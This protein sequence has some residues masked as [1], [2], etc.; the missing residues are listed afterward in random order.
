M[1]RRLT[2]FYVSLCVLLFL[3]NMLLAGDIRFL[4]LNVNDGLSQGSVF[5]IMQDYQ[6]FM[7]IGTR[8]GLNKYDSRKFTTYRNNPRDSTSI[9][10][11]F[12][13]SIMEDSR[14]RLWVATVDGL[15]LYNRAHDNF[16]RIRLS[17]LQ[18]SSTKSE[19]L[20]YH[21]MEDRRHQLWI[22]AST[23]LYRI[24]EGEYPRA[25]LVFNSIPIEIGDKAHIY[26]NFRYVYEDA[27]GKIWLCTD[28][29]VVSMIRSGLELRLADIYPIQGDGGHAERRSVAIYEMSPGVLWVATKYDGIKVIDERTR[30]ISYYKHIEGQKNSLPSNDVRSIVK[31]RKGRVWIGTFHGLSLFQGGHFKNYHAQDTQSYGL[32]NNSIRPIYED[33]R[34]SIWIGTYFGGLNII[35]DGIP[36][37]Q[38]FSYSSHPGQGLNFNVVS[39][40]AE[41]PD[42]T[43]IIGT[44]GGGLNFLDQRTGEFT[45]QRHQPGFSGSLSHNTIKA[46]CLDSELNLWVGTYEGGLNLRRRGETTFEHFRHDPTDPESLASNNVYSLLQDKKGDLWIATFGGGVQRRRKGS[47]GM[48]LETFS[49]HTGD[50]L[51]NMVR[52]LFEDS[53]G[54]LWI[55][56]E[57]GLYLKR[58][59]SE[60]FVTFLHKKG[61]PSTLSGDDV[62]SVH[63]DG[64]GRIWVG[65]NMTGLNLYDPNGDRFVRYDVD[66]GLAGN[67]IFGILHDDSNNLWLSTN[68]GISCLDPQTNKIRNY[69]QNDGLVGNEF[70]Y[71]AARRLSAGRFAFGNFAGFTI[72]HPDSILTNDF[73]PPVVF[74]QLRLF[75]KTVVPG[76]DSPIKADISLLKELVLNHTQNVFSL[77][78]SVLNYIHADKNKYAY[79][80]KNFDQQWNYVSMP[81]AT[82][83]NL[84]AG[85]YELFIKGA[86]NDG[87]WNESPTVLKIKILP[88]PWRTMWAYCIY[89]AI[90]GLVIFYGIRFLGIRNK[91]RQELLRE[92]MALE[93][94]KEIHEAKL[95]FFTHISHELRTP[96]SLIAGPIE[97]LGEQS[98]LSNG[99]RSLL[100][101]AS[102]SVDR[103]LHLV[104][105]LLDFRKHEGG[106]IV[107]QREWTDIKLFT[108]GILDSFKILSERN[109]IRLVL[110]SYLPEGVRLHV[111]K[112][113]LEKVLTNI[114]F[115]SFKFTPK[116]GS[117]CVHLSMS[118]S[119][120]MADHCEIAVW[121]TGRG[122]TKTDLPYIFDEFY[123]STQK[124]NLQIGSGIGLAL[125]RSLVRMHGGEITALSELKRDDQPYNTVVR[126]TLP[127]GDLADIEQVPVAEVPLAEVEQEAEASCD[128]DYRSG[129]AKVGKPLL[130]IV[131]DNIELR[132]F[133]RESLLEHYIIKE[134]ADGQQAWDLTEQ[135]V[136]DL[137]VSDVM[138]PNSDGMELLQKVRK[139]RMTCHIPVILL[140][141]RTAEPYV[142][143]AFNQGTDDYITKPFSVQLLRLKIR[144]MLDVRKRLEDR[145][146]QNHI[147]K[148][149]EEVVIEQN[150]FLSTVMEIVQEHIDQESFSVED[151]ARYCGMSRTVLYRKVK[152]FSGLN[153]VEF[154]NVVRLKKA[155]QLLET[156]VDITV[157]EVAYKVGFTDPKYFSKT[158][159]KFF[160]V[161]P[162]QY[163]QTRKQE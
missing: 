76:K 135:I 8:D 34:G 13:Q 105:Q 52:I 33:R 54:N 116:G 89:L 59:E 32:T 156:A 46:L 152:N 60:R 77:E 78:F 133:I 138:M 41:Q 94:Q 92:H 90:I 91:L 160:G 82:Y 144:N 140:T 114:L 43:L 85:N 127:V 153:V 142:L 95:D 101:S 134:A 79:F 80:L 53:K 7:W 117:I 75:N 45:Y 11:N 100:Q 128:N 47:K 12:V 25:E 162:S 20:V 96:L 147:V 70:I 28:Q 110:R 129:A 119:Q 63:E 159:K 150:S 97:R 139:T 68:A 149:T 21:I 148:P 154:I 15:N 38:N 122:V 64:K 48:K 155:A 130:L 126:I 44:E 145:F 158:F 120:D 5:A 18:S 69:D 10:S 23:G 111:D 103:L 113:Q 73:I 31:D 93:K 3:S 151:L 157:S 50:L 1:I 6:G 61:D 99:A 125:A 14:K 86:N 88:A 72:F 124:G 49:T 83:T 4:H 87:I 74:T 115:N 66:S 65:T 27:R 84:D 81:V 102:N 40:F 29:G 37:F 56:S 131:E 161:S 118:A 39:A 123:Q 104:N 19:P 143:E 112:E 26:R 35:D 109:N 16:S 146:I 141:A 137:I 107:L 121:D 132:S 67:N 9:G 106:Q 108:Q 98:E 163:V 42:G 36:E 58:P 62:I 30:T 71:G 2:K 17:N 55:G 51:S 57:R 22:A 136:P 24:I